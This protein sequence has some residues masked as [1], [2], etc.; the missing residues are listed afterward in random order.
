MS[1]KEK[2]PE[3]EMDKYKPLAQ[4][5]IEAMAKAGRKTVM[6]QGSEKLKKEIQSETKGVRVQLESTQNVLVFVHRGPEEECNR[7]NSILAMLF[8][9][10]DI[11]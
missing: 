4:A 9:L 6:I 11:N 5:L 8:E 3:K 2:M 7:I 1:E 10:A